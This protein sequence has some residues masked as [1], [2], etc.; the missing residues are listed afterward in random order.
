[1]TGAAVLTLEDTSKIFRSGD[2]EVVALDKVSLEVRAGEVLGIVGPSGS[3]KT[4]LLMIAG[5]IELPTYGLVKFLDNTTVRPDSRLNTLTDIRRRR[6]GFVF[7]RANLIPFLTAVENV[8]IAMQLD[9]MPPRD[10]RDRARL[11]LQE[12]GL[13][14]REG[15]L[16]HQLSGGEQQRV[17]IARALANR[18]SIVFADEPTAALDSARGRKV[19]ELFAQL[20]RRDGVAIVVVTHDQRAASLTDRIIQMADGRITSMHEN[21]EAL[22]LGH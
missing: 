7:Q 12:L 14:H 4:T 2:S 5:L 17:A 10:A 19:M 22:T 18:P 11:L 3:G 6:V 15:N 8:Q 21:P 20:A 16:P 9:G 13:I 1:M